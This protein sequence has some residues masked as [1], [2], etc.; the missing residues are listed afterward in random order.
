MPR[1]CTWSLCDRGLCHVP[2][3]WA[4]WGPRGWTLG[5][6]RE[7]GRTCLSLETW[8]VWSHVDG[9]MISW[10]RRTLCI[11]GPVR[12]LGWKSL[13]KAPGARLSPVGFPAAASLH[14]AVPL[15]RNHSVLSGAVCQGL[16]SVRGGKR[17]G[18]QQAAQALGCFFS[19]CPPSSPTQES[20]FLE[21]L[22]AAHPDP[23]MET[24]CRLVDTSCNN[25]LK[26][27]ASGH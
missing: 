15:P 12:A 16:A 11:Q 18:K 3:A 19:P 23:K 14:G 1:L 22:L 21:A 26:T 6:L 20:H 10:S 25:T 7:L 24:C 2:W 27:T 17:P 8:S 9:T 4:A 13:Q 5:Q